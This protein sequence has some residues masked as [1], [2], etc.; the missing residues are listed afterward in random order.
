MP[1]EDATEVA[2]ESVTKTETPK[3]E[4]AESAT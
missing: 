3:E 4:D 2:P 1:T